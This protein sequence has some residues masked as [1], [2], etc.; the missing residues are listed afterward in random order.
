MAYVLWQR[1]LR[2]NPKN[3][4][5][6]NRDRFVLSAG[7]GSMLL[8][9]LLH[10]TGYDLSIDD[11]KQFRQWGSP[12]PG[13]PENHL[14]PGVEMATG[15][16]GQGFATAVGMAIAERFLAATFNRPGH[17]L[18]DH[19]TYAIVSDGDVM[20]GIANEAA[21]LAGHLELGKLIFLYDDNAITIDGSTEVAFTENTAKRFKAQGWHIQ[22]V[23]GFDL[24]AVDEAIREAQKETDKPSIIFCKT[25]IG[26]GSPNKAGTP[27]VHGSPL[28]PDEVRL[29]KEA[30]GLPPDEAFWVPEDVRANYGLAVA[31]GKAFEHD[32]NEKLAAYAEAF[33]E[34]AATLNKALAGDW[35]LDWANVLPAISDK[36]ATR[37]A[38]GKVIQALA[39]SL[40]TLVGGSADLAESNLTHIQGAGEFQPKTPTGRNIA[41]GIREHAMAAIT[42]GI[43]LHGG[44]RAFAGTFLIFSDYC[45]PSLRLAALM[46]CPSIFVFTHDSIGL[47]ED[48]PT[49]QPVEHLAA[50]RAIPN[51]NV[52]RPA[53]AHETAAC[54][55][56][57]LESKTTPCAF[58]L[59][60]QAL[61]SVTPAEVANHPAERGAY[62]LAEAEGGAPEVVLLASGSEVALALAAREALS[63]EGTRARVISIPSALLFDRQ[64]AD[65]RRSVLPKGVPVLAIEAGSTLGLAKYSDDQI[66]LDRFGAS[67][68]A[69]TLFREFG[70]T[71]ENVSAR[72]KTLLS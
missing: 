37:A 42:N 40:P 56:I 29:T 27:K 52:L 2:H 68:P 24:E 23:D 11:L 64:D 33:P 72:V 10:L 69:E 16:L 21:S 18:I 26:F 59:T 6:F 66:G 28:G 8:Y 48:G 19:F 1:H 34:E 67:A 45:R 30:L 3:P 61:P 51:F 4:Q 20:E 5:W 7:H 36:I 65:Y 22:E 57:A 38:S 43:S 46:E 55:K 62:V 9:G 17:N 31:G 39:A 58:A 60:R 13:H 49:H 71:V 35:A 41:F 15:P 63:G 44:V 47:G 70:F 12:T 50:L 54:W 25:V 14:T 53:D 32:W